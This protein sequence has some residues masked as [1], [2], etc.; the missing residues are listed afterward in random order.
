MGVIGVSMKAIESR[1]SQRHD[2]AVLETLK[3][4]SDE[5]G[6]SQVA[7]VAAM[8]RGTAKTWDEIRELS[9][10][11]RLVPESQWKKMGARIKSKGVK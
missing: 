1:L 11:F 7:L 9:F 8:I 3:R 5:S 4:V 6:V 2:N 10:P